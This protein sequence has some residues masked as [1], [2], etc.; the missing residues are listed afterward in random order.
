MPCMTQKQNPHAGGDWTLMLGAKDPKRSPWTFSCTA[1]ALQNCPWTWLIICKRCPSRSKMERTCTFPRVLA[2]CKILPP[3]H[4]QRSECGK[5][6]QVSNHHK[7][8]RL[9]TN[10]GEYHA[11]SMNNT[12]CASQNVPHMFK[13]QSPTTCA[14]SAWAYFLRLPLLHARSECMHQGPFQNPNFR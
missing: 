8:Q 9:G 1:A 6:W 11:V 4:R 7:S 2:S 5:W 3:C 14:K 13:I 10:C 12:L